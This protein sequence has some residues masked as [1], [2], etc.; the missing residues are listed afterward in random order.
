ML[1]VTLEDKAGEKLGIAE[2]ASL[3]IR[4]AKEWIDTLKLSEKQAQFIGE[5][6]AEIAKRLRFLD[7]C[8]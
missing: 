6:R 3:P 4:K 8:K 5:V 7:Q 1:A 2:F